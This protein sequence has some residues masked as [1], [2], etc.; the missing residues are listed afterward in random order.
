MFRRVLDRFEDALAGLL[1]FLGLSI[2]VLEIAARSLFSVSFIWSEEVSRYTLIWL[3]YFGVAAAVRGDAH[4][5]V[6]VFVELLPARVK[7]W[8]EVLTSLV[9]LVFCLFV[10]WYGVQLVQ[11]SRSYGLMSAD[12]DLAIPIWAF[13]AI[14]PLGYLLVSLR[15]VERILRIWRS[16]HPSL[17]TGF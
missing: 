9:C 1:L 13:Q 3:T 6:T 16:R 2:V 10:A 15:L 11:D 17:T 5:K 12:S 14:V 8:L 4:I 7:R